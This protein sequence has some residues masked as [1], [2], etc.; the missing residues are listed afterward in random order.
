MS[1]GTWKES[2]RCEQGTSSER[3]PQPKPAKSGLTLRSEGLVRE[4]LPGEPAAWERQSIPHLRR[5]AY[6]VGLIG[7]GVLPSLSPPMHERE[8]EFHGMRLV[9]RPID[10][11]SLGLGPADLKSL[12]HHARLLGFNGLN[13]THPYKQTVLGL[14]DEVSDDARI[15]RSVNTVVFEDDGRTTGHNTDHLGFQRGLA[16]GLGDAPR[17]R[18]VQVGVGGAGAAVAFALVRS[19]VDR[20]T[21]SDLFPERAQLLAVTLNAATG[22]DVVHVAD[23][24]QLRQAIGSADGVV[25]ATP[26]GMAAHPGTSFD[27]GLL[28][29]SQWV[30]DVVYR[31]LR[32]EL[33]AKA[34]ALGCRTLD[35][36][37]MCVHQGA[38]AFR[39]FT[40][41]E[42]D[43]QRMRRI[44]LSLIDAEQSSSDLEK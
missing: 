11:P 44:F 27:V 23:S 31:P 22:R 16:E 41:R 7:D 21:I 33:L 36:G 3:W 38:E 12:L 35:G 14:L 28:S 6:L 37:R 5:P 13:I 10:L 9:Y 17:E 40:G 8:A 29:G 30:S 15:L 2:Q 43:P 42:P 25:N 19:G 26:V 24:A 20:L 4:T 1:N 18:V 39:L 34:E 32:T